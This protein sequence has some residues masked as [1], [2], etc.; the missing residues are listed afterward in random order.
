LQRCSKDLQAAVALCG[1]LKADKLFQPIV[2]LHFSWP[3]CSAYFKNRAKA[4]EN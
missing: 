3:Y 2:L 1:W 4:V